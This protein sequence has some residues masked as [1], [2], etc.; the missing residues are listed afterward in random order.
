MDDPEYPTQTVVTSDQKLPS[1]A[2]LQKAIHDYVLTLGP[3]LRILDQYV[4]SHNTLMEAATLTACTDLRE[5]RTRVQRTQSPRC[6]LRVCRRARTQGHAACVRSANG[7]RGRQRTRR[8]DHQ[9]Q[10]R[11]RRTSWDRPC[12]WSQSHRHGFCDRVCGSC[13]CDGAVRDRWARATFGH[14]GR[15]GRGWE[16]RSAQGGS[17]RVCRCVVDDVGALRSRK[18]IVQS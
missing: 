16:D 18:V 7:L 5:S 15:G 8:Q 9:L 3:K 10:R 4:S 1:N 12:V 6:Y 11:V 13:L 14:T 2:E 17:V